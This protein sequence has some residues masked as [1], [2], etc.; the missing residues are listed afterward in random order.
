MTIPGCRL[1]FLQRCY[2]LVRDWPR[3]GRVVGLYCVLAVVS[4]AEEE[5]PVL[6]ADDPHL[7]A[8]YRVSDAHWN[9]RYGE[10]VPPDQQ[11]E[12]VLDDLQMMAPT[13]PRYYVNVAIQTR[14]LDPDLL[15]PH[16]QEIRK[17]I[18]VLDGATRASHPHHDLT[19]WQKDAKYCGGIL[20]GWWIQHVLPTLPKKRQAEIALDALLE[21]AELPLNRGIVHYL[22]EHPD[23]VT[24]EELYAALRSERLRSDL[25]S[26]FTFWKI[27]RFQPTE[28]DVVVFVQNFQH[29][30]AK[31]NIVRYAQKHFPRNREIQELV[32]DKLDGSFMDRTR[33][34]HQLFGYLSS[35]AVGDL[36]KRE[37]FRRWYDVNRDL[38]EE[39]AG[40][41]EIMRVSGVYIEQFP[42]IP[43]AMKLLYYDE[44]VALENRLRNLLESVPDDHPGKKLH[45]EYAD[46][47][48]EKLSA[49]ADE[50]SQSGED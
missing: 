21:D 6:E 37:M 13:S 35:D 48:Q 2:D 25:H 23:L 49:I 26:F 31:T 45:L 43:H 42:A 41:A 12:N 28:E 20:A 9:R 24:R 36:R 46:E 40:P 14:K 5:P 47:R 10:E 27:E 39:A 4:P 1:D 30:T 38:V 34:Y 29:P 17:L 33:A 32:L 19:E 3:I 15:M 50:L 16:E 8:F 44:L 11:A 7:A 22:A 18:R